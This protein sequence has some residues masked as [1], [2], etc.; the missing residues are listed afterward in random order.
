MAD[1][2]AAVDVGAACEAAT[3]R[4]IRRQR[5]PMVFQQFGLLPWRTVRD[6][7][8]F[9]LELR[10][11]PPEKRHRIIE[12]QLELVGLSQWVSATVASSQAACSSG[13]DWR[14]RSRPM[15]TFC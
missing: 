15:R 4:H 6:N 8:G 1:G 11:D 12:Q 3:L 9:G 13:W 2:P 10:G 7:V 14:A 5:I